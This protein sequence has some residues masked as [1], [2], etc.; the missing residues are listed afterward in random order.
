MKKRIVIAKAS[1]IS[2]DMGVNV[3]SPARNIKGAR[4]PLSDRVANQGMKCWKH[5]YYMLHII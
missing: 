5:I 2:H 3:L 4:K 1:V